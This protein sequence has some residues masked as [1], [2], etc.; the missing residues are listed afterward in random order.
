ME[1]LRI[2]FYA[3]ATDIGSGQEMVFGKGN[4][5]AAVRASCSIPGIFRPVKIGGHTYVDGGVVSP[6]AV[7]AARRLG[8][9]AVIAVDISGEVDGTA[10]DGTLDTIFQSINIMYARIAA[11]QVSRAD[12]VIRPRVGHIA[13]GDF[14]R[15]HEAILEGEKAAQAALPKIQ[16]LLL[17]TP[18]R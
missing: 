10:P 9:D 2:P 17:G 5:G 11:D 13:S 15:R 6:V 18:A 4:T 1:N 7:D 14:T 16:G 12:V 8:A 3:V